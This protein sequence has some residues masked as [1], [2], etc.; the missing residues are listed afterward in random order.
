MTRDL[1]IDFLE[2]YKAV[3]GFIRD[4]YRAAEGVSEYIRIM[5]TDFVVGQA[6]CSSW[7]EEYR[8]LKRMRWIRN[9]LAHD[10]SIDEEICEED[11]YIWLESFHNRLLNTCDPLSVIR[12]HREKEQEQRKQA[13]KQEVPEPYRQAEATAYNYRSAEPSAPDHSVFIS[14]NYRNSE[15]R[16]PTQPGKSEKEKSGCFGII[17]SSVIIISVI[18]IIITVVGIII[19]N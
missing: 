16:K 8:M 3:D 1:N 7:G 10:V 13:D 2:E 11:D 19:G 18:L 15:K 12:I 17:L 4:A 9:K 6:Y 14:N 5:E